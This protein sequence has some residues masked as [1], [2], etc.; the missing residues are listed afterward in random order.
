MRKKVLIGAVA[1]AFF[2]LLAK[3]SL[4]LPLINPQ[5]N[6]I[7]PAV[8]EAAKKIICEKIQGK[9]ELNNEK[10]ILILLKEPEGKNMMMYLKSLLIHK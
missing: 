3:A 2:L 8:F 1:V 7:N 5:I 10:G 9:I 6:Q 4:A